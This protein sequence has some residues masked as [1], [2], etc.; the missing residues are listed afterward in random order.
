MDII[1]QQGGKA[2]PLPLSYTLPFVSALMF[3][4]NW[5]F[6]REHFL[7]N[8]LIFRCLVTTFKMSLRVFSSVWYVQ[9]FVTFL[10]KF[11]AL[12]V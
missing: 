8:Y 7:E 5:L 11:N 4:R 12:F 2:Y 1:V 9:T 3:S 10:V 6:S